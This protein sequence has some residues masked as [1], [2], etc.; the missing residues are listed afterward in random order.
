KARNDLV[1]QHTEE[2]VRI[3]LVGNVVVDMLG[4]VPN[5]KAIASVV[6]LGPPAVENRTIEPTVEHGLHAAGPRCFERSAGIVQPNVDALHQ[7]TRYVD[8]VVLQKHH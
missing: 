8:V 4:T 6:R 1:D 7:V 2:I 5:G 3:A